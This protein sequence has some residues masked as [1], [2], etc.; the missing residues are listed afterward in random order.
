MFNFNILS[1]ILKRTKKVNE[2][3]D[4][5]SQYKLIMKMK[6]IKLKYPNFSNSDY[7][8]LLNNE[9]EKV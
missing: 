3:K 2:E 8:K 1:S 5:I 6:F 9:K 7:V 4:K